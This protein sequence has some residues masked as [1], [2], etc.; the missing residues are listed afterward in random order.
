MKINKNELLTALSI[1]KPALANKEMIEQATSFA[2][3]NG[4]IVTFN[5]EISIKHPIPDLQL[6][7]AIK[8][9]ELY[10]LLGKIKQNEITI[11]KQ[12]NEVILK[13]GKS[14]A[15]FTL[16]KEIKLPLDE[17][18]AIS[19]FND[20][21]YNFLEAVS[22]T[23]QSC[24]TDY[25]RPVLTC[26]NIQKNG[27]LVGTDRFRLAEYDLK[28]E[29]PVD[30]FLLPVAAAKEIIKLKPTKIA[31]NEGWVHFSTEN[32]TVISCRILVGDFPDVAP[33]FNIEGDKL[34]LPKNI[35]EIL[36]RLSPFAKRESRIDESITIQY[37]KNKIFFNSKNEIGWI[38]EQA[39]CEY[40]GDEI[41][42]VIAPTFLQT[43]IKE[44]KEFTVNTQ[45]ILFEEGNWKYLSMLKVTEK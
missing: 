37:K 17:I 22:F 13:A 38:K 25:S 8:A 44:T 14:K 39:R 43:I 27:K 4:F 36:E 33:F 42:F 19:E 24:S 30:T 11:E 20:L 10:E 28:T 7:G 35:E 29:M 5:D 15:G 2:F 21:P 40:E 9:E 26:I 12:E 16:Q 6:E 18:G 3:I 1:V 41:T 34:E 31:L 32:G 45:R 23:S